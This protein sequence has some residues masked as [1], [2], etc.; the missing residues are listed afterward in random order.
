MPADSL[1]LDSLAAA[2]G[3]EVVGD[4]ATPIAD[5]THDSRA[6]GPSDLFVAIRGANLDGHDFIASTRAGAVCVDRRQDADMP[7]LVVPDTRAA[8]PV[9][10]ATVHGDPSHHLKVVGITG[11]NGKTTVAYL[12]ASIVSEAGMKPGVIGTV[13]AQ[14]GSQHL[15][16]VRTSPEASDFQRLLR[17]MVGGGVEVAA[18]EVSS[19]ALVFGRADQTRFAS[20]AFTNLSQDHLD[21]H[22]DMESYF[23]AK[24]LL[25]SGAQG[26]SVVNTD[27]PWGR[28]LADQVEGPLVTVGADG[29]VWADGLV[30][31]LSQSRFELHTPAGNR[32]VTLPLGGR[33]NVENALVAAGCAIS[34]NLPL[35][36]IVAGLEAVE[37]IAGRMEPIAAGQECAIVVD[38][39]HTPEGISEVVDSVRPLVAGRIIVVVG[40]GGDRDADKRPA[41]GRAASQ[42]DRVYVTSDNPRSEDPGMI[43]DAVLDGADGQ[44]E[45]FTE[46]DRR[47]AIGAAIAGAGAGDVV[48]ILG[49]G[50]ETGQEV[51]GTME[52]FDDRQVAREVVAAS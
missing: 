34:L 13:G 42:A 6:A 18:V 30:S 40:A 20:V 27:D 43:I 4:G 21:L 46:P 24:A 14:I 52:P 9:L 38:Y 5:V 33:F 7:L 10:A 28:R 3:G 15:D 1:T 23:Q 48:L 39:A 47:K 50:H 11:T 19:H 31:T 22:G 41:M 37:P 8:L 26:A 36:A 2:T 17:R 32:R 29:E 45:V 16:Q 35:D 25:F 49:K 44:A 12:L 51:A